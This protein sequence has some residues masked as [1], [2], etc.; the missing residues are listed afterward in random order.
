MN[1]LVNFV[2]GYGFEKKTKF[3]TTKKKRLYSVSIFESTCYSAFQ[4]E[5]F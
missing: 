3:R 2:N 1:K 5:N 4:D